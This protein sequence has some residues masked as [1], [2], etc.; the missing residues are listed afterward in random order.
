MNSLC[1]ARD[2]ETVSGMQ[3]PGL[4]VLNRTEQNRTEQ[5]RTG[6]VDRTEQNRTEQNRSGQVDRTVRSNL[7]PRTHATLTR[8][9]PLE[10]VSELRMELSER[11]KRDETLGLKLLRGHE[12]IRKV[13]MDR[14]VIARFGTSD[15]YLGP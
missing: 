15:V 7:P 6:Q 2:T 10:Q 14:G 3:L 12:T 1:P 5:N 8:G 13:R 4:N 11:N 9:V